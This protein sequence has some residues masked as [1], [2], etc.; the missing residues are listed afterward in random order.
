M[1]GFQPDEQDLA[2][3]RPE[4]EAGEAKRAEEKKEAK[5]QIQVKRKNIGDL[6][7]WSKVDKAMIW[8]LIGT[9]VW[10]VHHF[11]YG[12]IV[13]LG[14]VQG[15]EYARAVV[16][17]L[18]Q[19]DQGPFEL[20][21]GTRL[22]RVSF[23]LAMLGGSSLVG[24]TFALMILVQV[25]TWIQTGTWMGGYG[26]A[27]QG[28]P[29]MET[30]GAK[31]QLT[32]LFTVSAINFL[33]RFFLV[34]LPLVGAYTYVLMPLWGAEMSMALFN[35][36]R[37]VPLHIFWAFSPFS[38]ELLTLTAAPAAASTLWRGAFALRQQIE[39]RAQRRLHRRDNADADGSH[40]GRICIIGDLE[41][42]RAAVEDRGMALDMEGEDGRANDDDDIVL[43]QCVGELRRRGMQEARELR[44]SLGE[45]AARR[46][47]ADPDA[48]LRLLGDAHHQIDRAGAIDAGADD[49]GR[50]FCRP[51]R[52][53]QRFHCIRL[54]PISRLTL[55]ASIG[56][57]AWAQS[58]IGIDTKV[59]PQGGCIAV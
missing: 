34:F 56:A 10:G 50:V 29:N 19:A 14:M 41:D 52:S 15:P 21:Q 53:D 12:V 31:G 24:V 20:G 11:F 8:L 38:E 9:I 26:I 30:E 13:F 4:R 37:S 42:R 33:F 6:E 25:F 17:W 27:W 3:V 46:E 54:G 48:C 36:E 2:E 7:V 51:E 40:R 49:E 45:R 39:Q 23:V 57:V 47:R 22:D 35:M 58:S 59:G 1:Y 16:T 55:R 44:M 28:I 5:A 43:A 18:I 32:T